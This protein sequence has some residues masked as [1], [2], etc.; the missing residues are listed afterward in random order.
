MRTAAISHRLEMVTRSHFWPLPTPKY[1]QSVDRVPSFFQDF[2]P[3]SL[4]SPGYRSHTGQAGLWCGR[5]PEGS[6]PFL[7]SHG[8]AVGPSPRPGNG[9]RIECIH[10]Q[11]KA[12]TAGVLR[13]T[14]GPSLYGRDLGERWRPAH[15]GV[16]KVGPGR[17]DST[18]TVCGWVTSRK[19]TDLSVPLGA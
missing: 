14:Q 4:L 13:Q 8:S 5:L 9:S 7:H 11:T 1:F 19:T 17:W 16:S 12:T 2:P 3:Y 6:P 15:R 18:C 10:A